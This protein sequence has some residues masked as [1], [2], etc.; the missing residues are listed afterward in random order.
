MLKLKF[1]IDWIEFG[2]I[3]PL[4]PIVIFVSFGINSFILSSFDIIILIFV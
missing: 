2:F 1:E 3:N 4:I